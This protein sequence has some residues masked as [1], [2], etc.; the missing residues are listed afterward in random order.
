ML[1]W[2]FPFE[3]NTYIRIL[4]NTGCVFLSIAPIFEM[5]HFCYLQVCFNVTHDVARVYDSATNK[6]LSSFAVNFSAWS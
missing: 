2:N 1:L 6:S 3:V 4:L 5:L